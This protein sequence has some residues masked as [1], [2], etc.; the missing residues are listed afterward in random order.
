MAHCNVILVGGYS[1]CFHRPIGPINPGGPMNQLP[2]QQHHNQ[3][4]SLLTLWPTT[5]GLVLLS[6]PEVTHYGQMSYV[7]LP[8]IPFPRT[9]ACV[10]TLTVERDAQQG[11]RGNRKRSTFRQGKFVLLTDGPLM[12]R[13][14]HGRTPGPM[15]QGVTEAVADLTQATNSIRKLAWAL[16]Q[17]GAAYRAIGPGRRPSPT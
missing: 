6:A 7:R 5:H 9:A 16:A 1:P 3:D 11:V 14:V 2:S 4:L 8:E 10:D 13:H 17:R 12:Q 15:G